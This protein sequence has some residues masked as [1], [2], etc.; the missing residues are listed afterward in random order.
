MSYEKDN[1][2]IFCHLFENRKLSRKEFQKK[3]WMNGECVYQ[4]HTPDIE[5]GRDEREQ[6]IFNDIRALD[7]LIDFYFNLESE[8]RQEISEKLHRLE[9][10]IKISAA[11]AATSAAAW[12]IWMI[13]QIKIRK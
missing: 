7:N 1:G 9:P 12:M 3:Y 11:L 6:F 4:F 8:A 5:D 10:L 13:S 2:K